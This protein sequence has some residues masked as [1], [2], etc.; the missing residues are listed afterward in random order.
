MILVFVSDAE[1]A[2]V[3]LQLEGHF[4][5]YPSL[6]SFLGSPLAQVKLW[7]FIHLYTMHTLQPHKHTKQ[8]IKP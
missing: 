5:A 8:P 6:F 3:D 4:V 2:S 1:E 7:L